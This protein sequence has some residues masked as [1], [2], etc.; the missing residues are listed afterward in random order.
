M[1]EEFVYNST[2]ERLVGKD[3]KLETLGDLERE[4]EETI[5]QIE[6]FKFA[7]ERSG[8]TTLE[9]VLNSKVQQME[10]VLKSL[11]GLKKAR[12]GL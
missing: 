5:M 9:R 12:F 1:S 3:V 11:L 10:R 6:E 8:L 4:I 2:L 7:S